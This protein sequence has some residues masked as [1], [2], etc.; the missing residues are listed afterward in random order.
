MS[1]AEGK[2]MV[3]RR[4]KREFLRAEIKWPATIITSQAQLVGETK[5]VSQVGVS[6]SCQELPALG[7]EFRLVI[8]PPDRQPLIVTAKAIWLTESSSEQVPSRFVFGAEFEYISEDD[9]RFLGDV[10]ASQLQQKFTE[11]LKET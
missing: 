5:D 9:I 4:E 3:F 7:E 10:I 11:W 6:I 2:K 1:G 8:Q